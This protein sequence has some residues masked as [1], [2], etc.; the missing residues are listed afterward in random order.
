MGGTREA[1]SAST[2]SYAVRGTTHTCSLLRCCMCVWDTAGTGAELLSDTSHALSPP[3]TRQRSN[4]TRLTAVSSCRQRHEL[5]VCGRAPAHGRAA[6]RK[7][8][9]RERQRA[10]RRAAAT[11]SCWH[12]ASTVQCSLS[13]P[14]W[15][16]TP[17]GPWYVL[18]RCTELFIRCNSVVN[19]GHEIVD[20]LTRPH[21]PSSKGRAPS[22]CGL[23]VFASPLCALQMRAWQRDPNYNWSASSTGTLPSPPHNPFP[24]RHVV[25][26]H[27]VSVFLAVWRAV[28]TC[29]HV[30]RLCLC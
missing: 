25:K 29:H 6:D 7:E 19:L 27:S 13:S 11:A 2:K 16:S 3:Q 28:K 12:P 8:G 30:S 20:S 15:S 1:G 4:G 9:A 21:L 23:A 17:Q 26:V 18:L 14:L 10:A 24:H 5:A 22:H